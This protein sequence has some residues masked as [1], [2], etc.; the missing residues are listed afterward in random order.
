MHQF[1]HT[2]QQWLIQN[3]KIQ[4][5]ATAPQ[6][7]RRQIKLS[8]YLGRLKKGRPSSFEV[9]HSRFL[10]NY[11]ILSQWEGFCHFVIDEF[12]IVP[13]LPLIEKVHSL[14]FKGSQH[15]TVLIHCNVQQYKVLNIKW[16]LIGSILRIFGSIFNSILN[17]NIFAMPWYW[18]Y[19]VIFT[20]FTLT[21]IAPPQRFEFCI[22]L[23][24]WMKIWSFWCQL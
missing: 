3:L 14:F 15:N 9:Y 22:K 24:F 19:S 17:Q 16:F 6:Y 7:F 2:R 23:Y 1:K 18:I 10:E 11:I 20:H 13:L 12:I 4:L 8:T 21:N 5:H